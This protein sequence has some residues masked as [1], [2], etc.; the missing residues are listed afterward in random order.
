MTL[1]GE[2]GSNAHLFILARCSN[3]SGSQLQN[4]TLSSGQLVYKDIIKKYENHLESIGASGTCGYVVGA[5]C[6][7]A[8]VEIRKEFPSPYLLIP[9]IGAQGGDAVQAIQAAGRKVIIPISRA[10]SSHADPREA[11]QHWRDVLWKA[12]PN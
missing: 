4:A 7:E 1:G 9:G 8:I 5:T 10:I 12:L 11:A 2:G 3:P 6:I